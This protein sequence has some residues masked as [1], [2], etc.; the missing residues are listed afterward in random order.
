[1]DELIVHGT[2][3]GILEL[4]TLIA[5]AATDCRRKPFAHANLQDRQH[6]IEEV[7]TAYG[8]TDEGRCTT[9]G[10]DEPVAAPR[11]GGDDIVEIGRLQGLGEPVVVPDLDITLVGK[12]HRTCVCL[13]GN[14]C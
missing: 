10:L 4:Q 8:R 3:V 5:D 13:T 9:F 2:Q 14:H 11:R 6:S 1:M 7:A 12:S